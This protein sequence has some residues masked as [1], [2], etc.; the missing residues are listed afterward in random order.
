MKRIVVTDTIKRWAGEYAGKV[1]RELQP[2][3]ALESLEKQLD[4]DEAAYIKEVKGCLA[5]ILELLPWEYKGFYDK[6]FAKYDKEKGSQAVDL[7]KM[8]KLKNDK[9]EDVSLQLYQHIV[10]ALQYPAVQQEVFPEYV[11]KLGIRS[12]VYCNA[13]YAVSAKKG[14]TERSKPYRTTYTLDHWKPKNK[15]PYL[16]VAFYNLYPCCAP[17]NQAK[18]WYERDWMMY[19]EDTEDPNPFHFEIE[20]LSFLNYLRTWDAEDLKIE[21]RPKANGSFPDYDKN[22]HI[23]KMYC[24]FKSEVEDVIWRSRIYS[25][26]MVEA[27]QQSGVYQIKPQDVNR[28]IIGNYDREE[29]ILNRP[30]AKLIQDVAKQLGLI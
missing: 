8:K 4:G 14:K 21:F 30:L 18:S 11:R 15:F 1:Q 13:Q 22:F 9:G 7:G 26:K 25:P 12:C 19:C 28:F 5:E 24:N 23:S 10:N 16:A 27:M 3:T 29:Y 20:N 17:C 2:G 6:H